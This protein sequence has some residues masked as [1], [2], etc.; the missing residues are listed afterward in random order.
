M[1]ASKQSQDGTH[2]MELRMELRM[3]LEFHPD[4]AWGRSSNPA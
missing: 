3:E 1:T 2:G 4:F